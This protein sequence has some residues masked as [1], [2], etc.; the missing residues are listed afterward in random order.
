M[1]DITYDDFIPQGDTTVERLISLLENYTHAPVTPGDTLGPLVP[2]TDFLAR[3][4]NH[5]WHLPRGYGYRHGDIL[6][7]WTVKQLTADLDE[8][9]AAAKA[10]GLPAGF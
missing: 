5:Y 4:I 6:T 9:V 2:S 8:R 1:A 3:D 7:T 10:A